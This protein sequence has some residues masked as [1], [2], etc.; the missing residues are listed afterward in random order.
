MAKEKNTTKVK[1]LKKPSK[2]LAFW[3][4]EVTRFVAGLLILLIATILM[5]AFLSFFLTGKSDQAIIENLS[6]SEVLRHGNGISNWT[7]S[8]G[9]F[10]AEYCINRWIGVS[11]LLFVILL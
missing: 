5:M 4:S 7:G 6:A 1:N 10:A 11:S 9:A 8:F 3:R 2:I